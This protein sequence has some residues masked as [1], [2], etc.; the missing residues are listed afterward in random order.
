MMARTNE[1]MQE[2]WSRA[3]AIHVTLWLELAPRAP[4][5]LDQ[6]G[7]TPE[8]GSEEA[9]LCVTPGVQTPADFHP[10]I[11]SA[12]AGLTISGTD[13][14]LP[15]ADALQNDETLRPGPAA[16]PR[17]SAAPSALDR[18]PL[19]AASRRFIFAPKPADA[20]YGWTRYQFLN[21][22]LPKIADTYGV[23]LVADAYRQRFPVWPPFP[24]AKEQT[25]AEVLDEYVAPHA[26]W[27][28][29][30]QFIHVRR[31]TWYDDRLGE[32]PQRV[33]AA[34]SG[35]LRQRPVLSLDD[36]A[37]LAHSLTDP[38]LANFE[39]VMR[40]AGVC[41]VNMDGQPDVKA[42]RHAVLDHRDILR[43]YAA[44][45]LPQQSALQSGQTVAYPA[46]PGDARAW[47]R[48]AVAR[49]LRASPDPFDPQRASVPPPAAGVQLPRALTLSRLALVDGSAPG[50]RY[51]QVNLT[52]H[53]PDDGVWVTFPLIG[54]R[55]QI[56]PSTGDVDASP[57]GGDE[58]ARPAQGTSIW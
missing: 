23:N 21:N 40:E 54:P 19:L 4:G 31:W 11:L 55:V 28:R 8:A 39:D 48:A 20:D 3:T 2:G 51:E 24:S 13:A 43:C 30:G 57:Q 42:F 17:G 27:T 6:I 47:L 38:Q 46:M 32:I 37:Q 45:S 58:R 29:E 16:P 52:V 33:V 53:Y 50:G 26:H 35:R 25:L 41:M 14:A 9:T 22:V 49:R 10:S 15:S 7:R 34:W 36:M 56:R 1:A 12:P 44:L 5:P 18:S